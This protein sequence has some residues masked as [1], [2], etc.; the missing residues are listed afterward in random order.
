MLYNCKFGNYCLLLKLLYYIFV[1]I[2]CLYYHQ[3]LSKFVNLINSVELSKYFCT[4]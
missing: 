2:N 1:S 4:T 3:V